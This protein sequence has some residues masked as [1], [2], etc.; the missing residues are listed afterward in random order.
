MMALKPLFHLSFNKT[1]EG[2]WYPRAPMSPSNADGSFRS[3][4]VDFA[5]I[6]VS[7]S[8]EGCFYAIYPNVSS[9]FEERKKSYMDFYVYQARLLRKPKILTP[10]QLIQRKLVPDAHVTKEHGILEPVYMR[11]FQKIR[12]INTTALRDKEIWYHPFNDPSKPMIFL[13]PV[14]RYRIINRF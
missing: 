14:C 6:C 11:L 4:E 8:I 9:F 7:P 1:L 3:G 5:R 2:I 12:V 10:E 13:S